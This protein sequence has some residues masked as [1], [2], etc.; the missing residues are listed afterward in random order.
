[1]TRLY[2]EQGNKIQVQAVAVWD[3]V[4]ALGIPQLSLFAK[5]GFPQ[6]TKEFKFY[7]TDLQGHIRHAFQCLAL[8]EHRAP[9][10]A[11][12]WERKNMHKTTIDLR[13]VWVPG[14]HSNCGG[15]YEDQEIANISL[16]W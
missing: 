3:T 6:S 2:D 9:F 10:Q 12:V 15:G 4:G 14:A 16:A 13:Q 11:A 5:L 8:D 7:N 1:M